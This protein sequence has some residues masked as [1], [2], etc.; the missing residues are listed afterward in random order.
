MSRHRGFTLVELLAAMAIIGVLIAT[1]VP[2]Y[3]TWQ[4]R[5]YGSEAVIM[6]RQI[7][8]AQISYFLDHDQFFPPGDNYYTIAHNGET[9]PTGVDVIGA[10]KDNLHIDIPTGH[11]L[12]YG[13]VTSTEEETGE[14]TFLLTITAYG[15]FE[16]FKNSGI[17]S[18]KLDKDGQVTTMTF[19]E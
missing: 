10:I 8:D 4:Q 14:E 6:A 7:L 9:T 18:F 3:H 17:V 1:A 11:F 2:V 12:N 5:A 13:F 15:E 19:P 16:L